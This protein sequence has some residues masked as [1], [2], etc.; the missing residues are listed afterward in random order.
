MS[1]QCELFDPRENP[2]A[3]AEMLGDAGLRTAIRFL[4]SPV[5]GDMRSSGTGWPYVAKLDVAG[6]RAWLIDDGGAR[7][8]VVNGLV[9]S[10]PDLAI[11][12][13]KIRRAARAAI[14]MLDAVVATVP[15]P[16]PPPPAPVPWEVVQAPDGQW[17]I[18]RGGVVYADK[19]GVWPTPVQRGANHKCMGLNR[20]DGLAP[21]A[22]PRRRY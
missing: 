1:M 6:A 14:D 8:V 17:E 11:A 7:A 9:W 20:L 3:T 15:P 18:H 10:I 21:P 16:V 4:R 12:S 22:K 19:H 5:A 13:E 2:V